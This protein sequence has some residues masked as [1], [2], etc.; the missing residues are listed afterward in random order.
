VKASRG[1]FDGE[2]LV[3]LAE[4]VAEF[5]GVERIVHTLLRAYPK[6]SIVAGHFYPKT[7][8]AADDFEV[9]ARRLGIPIGTN[10]SQPSV[11]LVGPGGHRSVYLGP[12]YAQRLRA[13]SLEGASVVLSMGGLGWTLA[14]KVPPGSR[15]LGYI[16]G[17]PRPL[18][19]HTPHYLREQPR[20]KRPLLRASLPLLRAH[21]RWL[22]SR[23]HRLVTNSRASASDL[24]QVLGRLIDVIYPPARTGFFTPADR[25]REHYLA[26]A[27]LY[28]HKRLDVLLDAFRRLPDERL[29]IAGDGPAAAELRAAAPPNVTFVGLLQDD[30]LLDLYRSSRAVVTASVEEFGISSVEAH[31]C[32]IPVIG[33][34][35]G[36]TGEIIDDGRT[37]VLF[38]RVSAEDVLGSIRRFEALEL[39]PADCRR[40]AGRYSEER[41]VEQFD[42]MISRRP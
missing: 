28:L 38:E 6:A 14:A 41:F 2:G 4:Q 8:R 32:G 24:S 12:L 23:P 9:R 1:S 16:G 3:I 7:G 39:D 15:H 5:G 17:L 10:G 13:H 34:R 30:E 25:P 19:T 37:G 35:A 21:H 36:G 33:P 29:V 20:G 11:R 18:Y 27:R 31:A 40:A 42:A 26:V 22:L